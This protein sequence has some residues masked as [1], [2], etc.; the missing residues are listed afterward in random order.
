MRDG[1]PYAATDRKSFSN[2]MKSPDGLS[3]F[4]KIARTHGYEV[5][6]VEL[7]RDGYLIKLQSDDKKLPGME[8]GGVDGFEDDESEWEGDERSEVP[9]GLLA[10]E[11]DA[12]EALELAD[13]LLD[14]GAG[15]VERL[16]E[17]G[18]PVPGR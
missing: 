18:R 8:L 14:A 3:A 4:R 17:E 12:L 16:R 10:A 9:I 7:T 11:R 1:P 6:S 15:P 13:Q 2:L 5:N